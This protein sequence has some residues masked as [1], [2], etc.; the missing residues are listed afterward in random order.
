MGGKYSHENFRN[1]LKLA[2]GL[3][4]IGTI[5]ATAGLVSLAWL[6]AQGGSVFLCAWPDGELQ[7]LC[8]SESPPSLRWSP[9]QASA[10]FG[11]PN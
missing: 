10:L 6:L 3:N 9:A 11:L 5:R 7:A 4:D 1:I 2:V 8:M